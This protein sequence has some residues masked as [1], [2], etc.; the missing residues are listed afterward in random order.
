MNTDLYEEMK[1]AG[2]DENELVDGNLKKN[3]RK[4]VEAVENLG[5][6]ITLA[7][8]TTTGRREFLLEFSDGKKTLMAYVNTR[9]I[10]MGCKPFCTFA[11]LFTCGSTLTGWAVGYVKKFFGK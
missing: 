3:T 9:F 6:G 11:K 5:M 2:I 8:V 10:T 1:L 7:G 4:L